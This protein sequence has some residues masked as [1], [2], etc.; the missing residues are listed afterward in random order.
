V[1][2]TGQRS[3]GLP[4]A[5]IPAAYP[6]NDSQPKPPRVLPTALSEVFAEFRDGR[7]WI[8]HG[9][10]RGSFAAVSFTGPEF[11]ALIPML[12]S[13]VANRKDETK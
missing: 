7:Y 9:S 10:G 5:N 2:G 13:L 1:S 12:R 3:M 6:S 8:G 4:E 11:D